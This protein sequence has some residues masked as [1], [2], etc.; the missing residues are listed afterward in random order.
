MK[1][2]WV[3]IS[4]ALAAD[5]PR[6][7]AFSRIE[8][9][10][11]LQLDYDRGESVTVAGM[12]ARWGWS[13]GKVARFLDELS[14]RIDYP[15]STEEKQNQRGQITIQIADGTKADNEQI[16]FIDNKDLRSEPNRSQV[17]DGQ[18]ADRSRS[19][20][21]ENRRAKKHTRRGAPPLV[22]DDAQEP[23]PGFTPEFIA[24]PWAEWCR[25]KK[26]GN[27]RNQ[28][29]A[30]RM[31]AELFELSGGDERR[32]AEALK[33]AFR[34]GWQSFRWCFNNDRKNPHDHD[35]NQ[36]PA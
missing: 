24:G 31:L 20:P 17:D 13:R 12:A 3:P 33:D 32:A 1:G 35:T 23:P 2:V 36:N 18:K 25:T 15:E 8:A 11:S 27:Y 14:L 4:K 30:R 28:E 7:R 19:V 5:L 9:V 10:F 26:G 16:K 29:A 34:S 22:D 6:G 21:Q